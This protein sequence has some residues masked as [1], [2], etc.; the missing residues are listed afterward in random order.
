MYAK[1]TLLC[2]S[3][4]TVLSNLRATV[5]TVFGDEITERHF[6]EEMGRLLNNFPQY[7][8]DEYR[9]RFRELS[10]DI[11]YRLDPLI[12]E[13]ILIRT[14]LY[15]EATER[16]LGLSDV[17][18]PIFEEYLAKHNVPHHLK[19]LPIVESN[20]N[21]VAK[22]PA[23]AVG[24][25]QFMPSTGKMYHL[26]INKML[27][28][29]CDTY[30]ASDAAASLLRTLYDMYGDWPLALAAYNCG[31]GRLNGAIRKA[32]SKDYWE[33]RKFLP[34]ETQKYVPF[35]MATVYVGEYYRLHKLKPQAQPSDYVLTD[36]IMLYQAANMNKLAAELELSFEDLKFL[37]PAYYK[38][39]IPA[40]PQ[41]VAL[42]LP[43]RI[44]AKLRGY[45][46]KLEQLMKSQ[47]DNDLRAVR[48]IESE[49][50]I[51]RMCKAFRCTRQDFLVWNNLP[52]DYTFKSGDLV[53]IRRFTT[54]SNLDRQIE[55][56]SNKA[57]LPKKVEVQ[58]LR[59]IGMDLE[60]RKT[61]IQ[62]MI[63]EQPKR[64]EHYLP[65]VANG[66]SVP[67]ASQT[68]ANTRNNNSY[69]HQ[70][71]AQT[72]QNSQA[73]VSTANNETKA[74]TPSAVPNKNLSQESKSSGVERSEIEAN[75]A[76]RSRQRRVLNKPSE[77]E[78]SNTE[79][80]VFQPK[81]EDNPNEP[82]IYYTVKGRET[83]SDIHR[84]FPES[85]LR[86]IMDLNNLEL[87]SGLRAGQ[88]L[89]IRR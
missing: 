31:A 9:L 33:V 34:K 10:G 48:R 21:P 41:G 52:N 68:K 58:G 67:V 36:T 19:Y 70:L 29:R 13:R 83:L 60:E 76:Q 43:A 28:E 15:R 80:K 49:E 87:H 46:D 39:L 85:S 1:W 69:R 35:F 65:T 78:A 82:Y 11:D 44:V 75:L 25:W 88:V 38:S 77:S 72:N 16:I 6:I 61:V 64:N 30:K 66:S 23:S 14:E 4:F 54:S 32:Q 40:H 3:F 62:P 51:N 71:E 47:A 8:D 22:S 12:K 20:L 18:F 45:E 53:G 63:V 74:N 42:V 24:L 2:L 37:N 57:N 17:Y 81:I 79:I 26:Q 59:V 55:T 27:D 86:D 73:A 5:P 84:L 56:L 7:S 50:D 89:K